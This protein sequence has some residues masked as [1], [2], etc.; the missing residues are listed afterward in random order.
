MHSTSIE[1]TQQLCNSVS[2]NLFSLDKIKRYAI[3]YWFISN[4]LEYLD[5]HG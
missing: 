5:K 2:L 1:Y 3:F 4:N